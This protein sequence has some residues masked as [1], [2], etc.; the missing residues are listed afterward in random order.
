VIT[1]G[2][3]VTRGSSV[4]GLSA[5]SSRGPTRNGRQAP[6]IAAPGEV[7]IAAQPASTGDLYGLMQ[8]TSMAAPMVTG[9]VA[10]MLERNA[11][12]TAADV[13]TR[14]M[15]TARRDGFTGAA[16]GNDW[17]AGK[18]DANAAFQAS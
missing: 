15:N 3:Y 10:L 17:G 1:V 2:S 9:A 14:L 11:T 12:L 5:F 13:R 4:G 16:A 8:G 7:L 6:T 18:L